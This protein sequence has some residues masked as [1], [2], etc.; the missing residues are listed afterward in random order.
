MVLSVASATNRARETCRARACALASDSARLIEMP[1][2]TIS[3]EVQHKY[4]FEYENH[5]N[6]YCEDHTRKDEKAYKY[7]F[8]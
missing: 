4:K 2:C 6:K 8:I 1:E 7:F 5:D 3:Q